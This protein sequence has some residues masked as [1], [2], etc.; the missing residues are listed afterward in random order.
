MKCKKINS[1]LLITVIVLLFIAILVLIKILFSDFQG[2]EWGSVTDWISALCNIAMAGAAV[3]AA[4]H[5]KRW[6]SQHSYSTAFNKAAEFLSK[7]DSEKSAIN[8]LYFD[9]QCLNDF[10]EEY[11]QNKGHPSFS[12]L[13]YYDSRIEHYHQKAFDIAKLKNEYNVLSRWPITLSNTLLI[14]DIL[15]TL[16]NMSALTAASF[17]TGKNAYLDKEDMYGDQF[18]ILFHDLK[19]NFRDV[20][21]YLHDLNERYENYTQKSF[22]D[23]FTSK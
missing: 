14:N 6:F 8:D 19:S 5:A 4:I 12:D 18:D 21:I 17:S 23:F 13:K 16:Q 15:D 22:S 9:V 1:Y 20:Q 2:F 10:F 7:I 11:E 3:Y